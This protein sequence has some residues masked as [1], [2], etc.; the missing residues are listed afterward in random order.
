MHPLND[1]SSNLHIDGNNKGPLGI[2]A[3]RGSSVG[4]A[5][6]WY[7]DGRGFDPHVQQHYFV[8]IGHEII[9]TAILSLP[10]IQGQLSATGKK[11]CTKC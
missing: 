11:M 6:A 2:N 3:G 10:L 8:E 9:S 4:C 1:N 7:A 5:F